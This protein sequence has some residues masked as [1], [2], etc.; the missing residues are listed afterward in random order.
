MQMRDGFRADGEVDA[1][2]RVLGMVDSAVDKYADYDNQRFLQRER[3]NAGQAVADEAM[4][5]VDEQKMS[6]P[7]PRRSC[8]SCSPSRS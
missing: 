5:K 1:V 6:T 7:T 2:R 4:G 3:E 8:A